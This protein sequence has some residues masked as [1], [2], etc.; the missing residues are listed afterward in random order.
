MTGASP[1]TTRVA[2]L[3]A[4]RAKVTM[5]LMQA[6]AR[7]RKKLR[8]DDTRRKILFG[9]YVVSRIESSAEAD[10]AWTHEKWM[11]GMD[12]YLTRPADRK[13]FGLPPREPPAQAS[14]ETGGETSTEPGDGGAADPPAPAAA[15]PTP[16]TT[17]PA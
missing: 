1:E 9:A 13:L 17:D 16:A 15:R 5:Q 4:R 14:I 11:V 2:K 12:R 3:E 6:R 7:E 10:E 8:A